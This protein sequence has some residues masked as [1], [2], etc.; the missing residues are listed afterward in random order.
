MCRLLA[1]VSDRATTARK[2]VGESEFE[3]FLGLSFEHRDGWGM[4]WH[5]GDGELNVEKDVEAAHTSDLL[6]KLAR[7]T[8]MD[9][10][11][12]HLRKASP[13]MGVAFENTHPFSSGRLAFAHN[14][15][16]RPVAELERL[17][18]PAARE[19]LR[20]AT[21]SERYFQLLLA[22]VEEA[23]SVELALP[24]LL[25]RLRGSFRYTALNF[26]LL[27]ERRLYAVCDFSQ[28]AADRHGDPDYYTLGYRR[29]ADAV[30]VASSGSWGHR[31]SWASVA[32]HQA[33]VVD[34]DSLQ[35]SLLQ[36]G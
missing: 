33:L 8:E 27:T 6:D 3:S 7:T 28:G 36:V 4:G 5:D 15:W 30:V 13:G 31:P 14:G 29:T 18:A 12:L 34:R 17:L 26:V 1:F 19:A 2:L 22:Q 11:V 20:G 32:N 21:D 24:P 23:G 10:M 25:E 16:I 35:T 9:A